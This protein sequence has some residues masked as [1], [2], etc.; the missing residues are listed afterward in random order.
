[1]LL[2]TWAIQCIDGYIRS[3]T[4]HNLAYALLRLRVGLALPFLF[5]SFICFALV[6][7]YS[8]YFLS[9]FDF[10]EI[11]YFSHEIMFGFLD[12]QGKV[13]EELLLLLAL[14]YLSIPS[15]YVNI[16]LLL[17]ND[18]PIENKILSERVMVKSRCLHF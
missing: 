12:R 18:T 6:R 11:G 3:I 1:M 8:I 17:V 14:G 7:F 2:P 9:L 5:V 16:S 13:Q 15:L 10:V 4:L